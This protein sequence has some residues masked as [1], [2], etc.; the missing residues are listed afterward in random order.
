MWIY[1]DS[2]SGFRHTTKVSSVRSYNLVIRVF[3]VATTVNAEN[4]GSDTPSQIKKASITKARHRE[5]ELQANGW[6]KYSSGRR[7]WG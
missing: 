1:Q 7:S 2:R 4:F 3:I 6:V 5:N